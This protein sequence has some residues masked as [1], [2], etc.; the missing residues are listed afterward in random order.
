VRQLVLMGSIKVKSPVERATRPHLPLRA[1]GASCSEVH[2]RLRRGLTETATRQRI[3]KRERVYSFLSLDSIT[4][5]RLIFFVEVCY[6]RLGALFD[7]L[8]LCK[9]HLSQELN[10]TGGHYLWWAGQDLNLRPPPCEGDVL[11]RLDYRP[12]TPKRQAIHT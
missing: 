7:S 9:N 4:M 5:E 1:L 6:R 3:S 11:T 2:L 12:L 8:F 10:D